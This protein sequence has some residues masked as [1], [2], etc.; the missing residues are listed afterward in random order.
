MVAAA[1]WLGL[2]IYDSEAQC[3]R[4]FNS[5]LLY[6]SLVAYVASTKIAP[7]PEFELCL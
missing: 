2:V 3:K 1:L 4:T 7:H 6:V 5:R